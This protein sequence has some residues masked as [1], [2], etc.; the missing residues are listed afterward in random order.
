MVLST[1]DKKVAVALQP[2]PAAAD[3]IDA[4]AGG[5]SG[6]PPP[7]LA[8]LRSLYCMPS[9]EHAEHELIAT[10]QLPCEGTRFRL[11]VMTL[12]LRIV[13][14]QPSCSAQTSQ[15]SLTSQTEQSPLHCAHRRSLGG[16]QPLLHRR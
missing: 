1:K 2:P 13:P 3:D 15:G 9:G 12:K 10:L 4:P 16:V 5:S 7:V 11:D 6:L 14:L 8:E